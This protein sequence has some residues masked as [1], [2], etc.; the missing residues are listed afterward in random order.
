LRADYEKVVRDLNA[1][2]ARVL[3]L[4]RELALAQRRQAEAIEAHGAREASAAAARATL[5]A[6]MEARQHEI[7][8]RASFSWWLA[9]PL[10]RAWLAL[11]GKP[12]WS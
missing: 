9:L 1:T 5:D 2:H 7:A 8:R 11:K 3:D 12:P 4:E 10:R 6:Q